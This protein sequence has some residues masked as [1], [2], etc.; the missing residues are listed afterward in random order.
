M[1]EK[2][3]LDYCWFFLLKYSVILSMCTYPA[4]HN[5]FSKEKNIFA[6]WDVEW[7]SN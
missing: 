2:I 3:T 6:E 5:Y 1:L 7:S 4:C